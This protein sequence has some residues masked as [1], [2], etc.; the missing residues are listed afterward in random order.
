[1]INAEE[2]YDVVLET[3]CLHWG[4]PRF[5]GYVATDAIFL[6]VPNFVRRALRQFSFTGCTLQVLADDLPVLVCE[7]YREPFGRVREYPHKIL[8]ISGDW[9]EGQ[10]KELHRLCT[11][12]WLTLIG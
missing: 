5:L 10:D 3:F 1:V 6:E 8:A 2:Q 9:L 4:A 11:K 7:N 12:Y